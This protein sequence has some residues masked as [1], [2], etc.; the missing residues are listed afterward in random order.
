MCRAAK[1]RKPNI[2]QSTKP[3]TIHQG[4]CK[5]E[6]RGR[7]EA[8]Y[9]NGRGIRNVRA[10]TGDARICILIMRVQGQVR[11][12]EFDE[13]KRFRWTLRASDCHAER[14]REGV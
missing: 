12:F 11:G 6:K 3:L 4:Q 10:D 1:E 8:R 2:K 9:T 14:K 7:D 5:Y 13:K